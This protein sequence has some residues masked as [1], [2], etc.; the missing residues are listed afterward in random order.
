MPSHLKSCKGKENQ[1]KHYIKGISIEKYIEQ[2]DYKGRRE[3]EV[4]NESVSMKQQIQQINKI[5]NSLTN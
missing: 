5:T 3:L 4:A 2:T 1:V